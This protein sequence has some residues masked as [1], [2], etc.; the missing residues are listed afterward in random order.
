MFKSR[1]SP[2]LDQTRFAEDGFSAEGEIGKSPQRRLGSKP[3][4]E[5]QD[6]TAW[7][8]I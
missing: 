8:W 7:R 1:G 2:R 4:H 5:S 3:M 6:A